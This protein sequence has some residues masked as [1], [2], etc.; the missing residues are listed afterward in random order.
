MHPVLQLEAVQAE[1]VAVQ[2]QLEDATSKGE[3]DVRKLVSSVHDFM[4]G[5]SL[6]PSLYLPA[7]IAIMFAVWLILNQRVGDV[8]G[9]SLNVVLRCLM[10][11]RLPLVVSLGCASAHMRVFA[12][13]PGPDTTQQGVTVSN[14]G[15][16]R[17]LGAS[18]G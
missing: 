2:R 11:S 3:E 6:P 15:F 9:N 17:G 13:F 10:L 18:T 5:P 8:S 1:R 16:I 4:G 7:T 14:R 12:F